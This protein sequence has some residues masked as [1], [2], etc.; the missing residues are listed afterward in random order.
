MALRPSH[1]AL[2]GA[3]MYHRDSD[4]DYSDEEDESSPLN[5]EIYGGR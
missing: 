2:D 5:Q 4:K 1:G 3:M